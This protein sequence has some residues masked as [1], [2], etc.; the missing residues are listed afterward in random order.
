LLEAMRSK[1]AKCDSEKTKQSGNPKESN[2]HLLI[3]FRASWRGRQVF[4]G[5]CFVPEEKMQLL[6]WFP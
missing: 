4:F 1:G 3:L 5:D 2:R 6:T